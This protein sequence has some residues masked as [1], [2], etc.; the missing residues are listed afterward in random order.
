MIA[1]LL[2]DFQFIYIVAYRLSFS[3]FF[4]KSASQPRAAK[5]LILF[6]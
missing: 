3:L 4:A 1:G 5:R 6:I 2:S